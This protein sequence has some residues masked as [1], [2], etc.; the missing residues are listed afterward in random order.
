MAQYNVA[1]IFS[2]EVK[3][4]TKLDQL[5]RRFNNVSRDIQKFQ[6]RLNATQAVMLAMSTGA[7]VGLGR[8]VVKVGGEF[9]AMITRLARV[10]GGVGKAREQFALLN[11]DFGVSSFAIND[12]AEAYTKLRAAGLGSED[13]NK[14]LRGSAE[15]VA[16]FG[17]NTA[18]LNRLITGMV[19]SIGKGTLSMEEMRQQIGEAVP[20]SMRLLAQAYNTSM[21]DIYRQIEN[22]ALD[23]AEAM[24]KLAEEYQKDFA[25]S[26]AAQANTIQGS[27]F[28][29]NNQLK[30]ATGNFVTFNSLAGAEFVFLIQQMTENLVKF[31]NEGIS[32]H[33]VKEFFDIM[34]NLLGVVKRFTPLFQAVAT[35]VLG[36]F[37]SLTA[38]LNSDVGAFL[39]TGI[40]AA[41]LFGRGKDYQSVG[42]ALIGVIAM[43]T[44][45]FGQHMQNLGDWTNSFLS[46]IGGIAGWGLVGYYLFGPKQRALGVAI[47][48]AF[49][50][51]ETLYRNFAGRM[52][53]LF[54]GPQ[55][56]WGKWLQSYGNAARETIENI[57]NDI[58]KGIEEAQQFS[59]KATVKA[60]T[61][62]E[63]LRDRVKFS[64]IEAGSEAA[65]KFQADLDK[66][67]EKAAAFG[68]KLS[69][70][71]AEI[72]A[73]A[74]A[75]KKNFEEG[76]GQLE[77]MLMLIKEIQKALGVKV[78]EGLGRFAERV[79]NQAE[80]ASAALLRME[81][82]VVTDERLK[83]TMQLEART[84]GV[85]TQLDK[86][87]QGYKKLGD[88]EGMARVEE[89]RN[90]LNSAQERGIANIGREIGANNALAASK[91]KL[92]QLDIQAEMLALARQQR[93]GLVQSFTSAFSDQAED[94]R[95]ELQRSIAERRRASAARRSGTPCPSCNSSSSSNS[96]RSPRRRPQV[97]WPR[98][99]GRQSETQFRGLS[100]VRSATLSREPSMRKKPCS[101]STTRSRTPRSTTSSSLS[102]YSSGS[103]SLP[104]WLRLLVVAVGVFLACSSVALLM[105]VLSV[106]VSLHLLMGV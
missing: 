26:I 50:A 7:L 41:V 46:L 12:M 31:I 23:S 79:K 11:K 14:I 58:K 71:P 39:T 101:P 74:P 92:N 70:T 48:S 33:A 68:E 62:L 66:L 80:Q 53:E 93:G 6:V 106:V 27:L 90:R 88:K 21:A 15:A 104:L 24:Q 20:S 85:A 73:M 100:R 94:R 81:A 5:G 76:V 30:A 99:L 95:L 52:A 28:A 47:G 22:G 75:T 10:E 8:S 45:L 4:G 32:D 42:R 97:Y 77:I 43:V 98:T 86:V 35:V 25:G 87:Y 19:Q 1:T 44:S 105:G 34:N 103:R 102:R 38:F 37:S 91:E 64:T 54:E 67:I 18:Q 56:E 69:K 49:G 16:A 3:N 89:M 65:N 96:R 13:A 55:T 40:V 82:S 61:D 36:F 63:N 59:N 78:A 2:I 29:M 51:I 9:Q 72:K 60:V 17:G 84:K 83:K 57:S